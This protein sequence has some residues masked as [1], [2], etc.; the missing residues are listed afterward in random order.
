MADA[1]QN[2]GTQQ[3][4]PGTQQQPATQ[5][6]NPGAS[7]DYD[8]IQQMIDNRTERAE[9]AVLNSYFQQLGLTDDEA[10]QALEAFKTQKAEKG[11]NLQKENEQLKAQILQGKVDSAISKAATEL[12]I[13]AANV[14]YVTKL[15]DLTG[16]T[17]DKGEVDAKKVKEALEKVLTDVPA[18]KA[19]TE[20][21]KQKGF[22]VGGKGADPDK[23]DEAEKRLRAAFGLK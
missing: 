18:F 14:P 17:N 10:K 9:K 13:A 23:A 2:P 12:G 7:I 3:Q 20:P 6:Q 5:Q 11:T 22:Q 1:N 21:E 4:D 15:A 19:T 16:A 8:K